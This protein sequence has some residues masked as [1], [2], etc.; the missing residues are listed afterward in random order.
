MHKKKDILDYIKPVKIETPDQAFFDQLAKKVIRENPKAKNEK[1]LGAKLI[2]MSLAAAAVLLIGIVL[3]KDFEK[4]QKPQ[5]AQRAFLSEINDEEIYAYVDAHIDDF[6]IDEIAASL[7]K[8]AL[9]IE[10]TNSDNELEFYFADITEQEIIEYINREDI[11]LDELED[12]LLI[13]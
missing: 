12:E 3:F 6:S 10:Y 4:Q 2:K 13:F 9:A 1:R 11:D 7:S 5:Q 8:D